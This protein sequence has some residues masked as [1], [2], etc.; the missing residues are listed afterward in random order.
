MID[1]NNAQP[2][3]SLIPKGTIAKV[4]ME[5]RPANYGEDNLLS[6]SDRTGSIGLSVQFTILDGDYKGRMISQLIGIEGTKLDEKGRDKWA[7]MG[8]SL[9]RAILESAHNIDPNDDSER[10]RKIRNI[11]SYKALDRLVCLVNIG[12]ESDKSGK[13]P[14]KNKIFM[15]ITPD[16]KEYSMFMDI[17]TPKLQE[18]KVS[19]TDFSSDEIPF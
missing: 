4:M 19:D 12:I 17:P 10:A 16:K 14:D 8:H 5:V 15:A 11:S 7:E 13:Y 6:K 9:I 2:Q 18:N 1:F 3:F